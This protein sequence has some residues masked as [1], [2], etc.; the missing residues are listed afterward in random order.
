MFDTKTL[1]TITIRLCSAAVLLC[2]VQL[3]IAQQ[4]GGEPIGTYNNESAQDSFNIEFQ[5]SIANLEPDTTIYDVLSFSDPYSLT[6]YDYPTLKALTFYD[7]NEQWGDVNLT[8]GPIGSSM[9]EFGVVRP[10]NTV[11]TFGYGTPYEAYFYDKETFPLLQSNR[12]FSYA[13]FSPFQGQESFIVDGYL[14][15]NIGRQGTL[16]VGFKR[17]LQD[18]NYSNQAVRASSMVTA[19]RYRGKQE[20][21]QGLFT[22]I[23]R[24]SDE[25][26]NGGIDPDAQIDSLDVN[27]RLGVPTQI[28]GGGTS[29]FH[30]YA[31]HVDNYYKL[32]NASNAVT[33]HHNAAFT[34]GLSK[35]GDLDVDTVETEPVYFDF[36][37]DEA[38]IRNHNTFNKFETS[39]DIKTQL[40][41]LINFNG[42]IGY[43]RFSLTFDQQ[44][45]EVFD[46]IILGLNGGIDWKENIAL[47]GTIETSTVNGQVY[48]LTSVK[49]DASINDVISLD[50]KLFR[51]TYPFAFGY[52]TLYVN[53][54][55]Q[56]DNNFIPQGQTG[57]E[58]SLQSPKTRSKIK[59]KVA[60]LTDQVFFN[61]RSLPTQHD[62][63][64]SL[65]EIHGTQGFKLGLF[66]FDNHVTYQ[67]FSDNIWHLPTFY[68]Q[69][70]IYLQGKVFENNLEYKIGFYGRF[71]QSDARISYQPVTRAFYSADGEGFSAF[72]RID[73]Y[74]NINIRRFE[75]FVR[76]QNIYNLIDGGI[77][78]GPVDIQVY[79]YPHFDRNF[80][81]GVKWLLKD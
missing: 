55:L 27:L 52:N 59:L 61:E 38:G 51:H 64:V 54:F 8:L 81:L 48:N 29:R 76:F 71:M 50:A 32:G 47:V 10:N 7:P 77:N 12:P 72:P 75:A 66:N 19:Y 74:L 58:G 41:D 25:M 53:N 13:G 30:D 6:P 15:Q 42:E 68:S 3:A 63:N 26:I 1:R 43:H 60:N 14:S 40:F 46:Q 62:E 56:F 44:A 22:Y 67:V 35:Y 28:S 57:V 16:S 21:Y 36:A 34:Y 9:R 5:D 17:H 11:G 24:F 70:D 23:G 2:I 80:R 45:P 79:R 73:T 78:S 49:L 37:F 4:R 20:R 69:H 33:I 18:D 65:F 39:A 31:F